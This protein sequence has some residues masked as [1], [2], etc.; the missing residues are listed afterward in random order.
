[1]IHRFTHPPAAVD[2]TP[3][4]PYQTE[5]LPPYLIHG[6]RSAAQ[7]EQIAVDQRV[8]LTIKRGSGTMTISAVVANIGRVP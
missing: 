5:A 2:A 7:L 6:S 3:S 8:E 4:A 1:M